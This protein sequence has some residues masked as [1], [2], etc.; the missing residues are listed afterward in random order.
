MTASSRWLRLAIGANPSRSAAGRSRRA[1]P[2]QGQARAGSAGIAS[3]AS[4]AVDR[5]AADV[6]DEQ[7]RAL[8]AC[9]PGVGLAATHV[10]AVPGSL[11]RRHQLGGEL[12]IGDEGDEMSHR[13]ERWLYPVRA[14]QALAAA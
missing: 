10:D 8:L 1:P 12:P 9:R 4:P 14:G 13:R 6:D 2:S 7:F 5:I 3:V 11:D